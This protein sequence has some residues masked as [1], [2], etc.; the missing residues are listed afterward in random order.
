MSVDSI[1]PLLAQ[2][3]QS[4]LHEQGTA[5]SQARVILYVDGRVPHSED[6]VA[7]VLDQRAVT[8]RC[9]VNI[10]GHVVV[11]ITLSNSRFEYLTHN[12][13]PTD[14]STIILDISSK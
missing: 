14:L 2:P 3:P 12:T 10:S 11:L 9:W 13:S 6:G 8:A 4:V 5:D 1:A 7:D